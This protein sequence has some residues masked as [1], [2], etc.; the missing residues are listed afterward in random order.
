MEG[1]SVR[2]WRKTQ[3]FLLRGSRERAQLPWYQKKQVES[4]LG[5]VLAAGVD[6]AGWLVFGGEVA[7]SDG[8]VECSSSLRC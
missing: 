6:V 3:P 1:G 7:G 5:F 2:A 8:R 4:A